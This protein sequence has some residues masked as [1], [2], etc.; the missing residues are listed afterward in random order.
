MAT[1]ELLLA[2]LDGG[3]AHGYDLKRARDAWFPASRPLAFGQVYATLRRLE[4]DGFVRVAETQAVNG[5]ERTV[6]ALT[7]RGRGRL[8]AWLHEAAEAPEEGAGEV[9]RKTVAALQTGA[10]AGAFLARQRAALEA[11]VRELSDRPPE[12]G[13]GA[14]LARDHVVAHLN[15]DLRWLEAALERVGA[16]LRHPDPRQ[17]A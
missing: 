14:Q 13:T 7:S 8:R 4:R 10:D 5:P 1:A 12:P 3:A 17:G 15:A 2:L 11:R 9:V 6:Y 16:E